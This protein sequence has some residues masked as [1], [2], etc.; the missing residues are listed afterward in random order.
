MHGDEINFIFGEAFNYSAP[1]TDEEKM[2][3]RF[4]MAYWSNFAKFGDPNT[5]DRSSPNQI[6]LDLPNWPE[7]SYYEKTFLELSV[8]TLVTKRKPAVG[9]SIKAQECAVS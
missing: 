2:L 3:T 1:Y 9:T 6:N 5:R 7:Y 4:I 8:D